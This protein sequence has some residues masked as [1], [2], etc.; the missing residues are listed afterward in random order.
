MGEED[1]KMGT[2]KTVISAVT[3]SNALK[4]AALG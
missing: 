2:N 4:G 1:Q 3:G